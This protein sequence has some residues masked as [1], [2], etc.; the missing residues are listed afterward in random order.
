MGLKVKELADLAGV[1][2][3]TLHYYDQIGLLTPSEVSAKGFRIYDGIDL[4][5]LQQILF[6]RELDFSLQEIKAILDN[7]AFDRKR[8]LIL[9]KEVLLQKKERL[10][11]IIQ[12]VE[13]SISAMT[14]GATM[15]KSDL[16]EGF[17]KHQQQYADE[18][19]WRFNPKRVAEAEQKT[20]QYKQADWTEIMQE[21]HAIY[22]QLAARMHAGPDD[23]EVQNLISNYQQLITKRFYHC[24]P[25]I[26][27]GLGQM[28]VQD[29]RFTENIDRTQAG[30]AQFLHEAIEIYV[31]K[32]A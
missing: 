1:S 28:Y 10:E 19:R 3:R 20:K 13:R 11:K 21:W 18:V 24:T 22:E 5:R 16:F 7:P 15:H 12:T 17:D 14:G 30:L 9:H 4:E 25:E 32:E 2:V 6:F 23:A 8:A 31:K 29:E 27:Q 26:L